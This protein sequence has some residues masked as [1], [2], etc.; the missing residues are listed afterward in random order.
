MAKE[1]NIVNGN[2]WKHSFASKITSL[3]GYTLLAENVNSD[4]PGYHYYIRQL[5]PGRPLILV[6]YRGPLFAVIPDED[7]IKLETGTTSVE[8]YIQKSYFYF[9]YFWGGGSLT[10]AYWMPLEDGPGIHET[11][12]ISRYLRIVSCR[13]HKR[14][15]G[16]SPTE[17]RCKSCKLTPSTCPY[18][19]LNVSGSWENEVQ[20]H[21]ARLNFFEKLEEHLKKWGYE[22]RYFLAH[23]GSSEEV[24]L[25]I[26]NTVTI[27]H[28]SSKL[29][30]DMLYHPEKDCSNIIQTLEFIAS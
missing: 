2:N 4:T 15:S 28:I 9:G 13:T 17:D 11:E 12:K 1:N 22:V 5:E 20:E 21:D 29:L 19:P 18:S 7:Y 6:H 14:S 23:T 8:E 16:Y 10:G 27:P 24:R 26:A 3:A 30:N 25:H